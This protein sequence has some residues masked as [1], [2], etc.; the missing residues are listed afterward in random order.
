MDSGLVALHLNSMV[1]DECFLFRTQL[2]LRGAFSPVSARSQD[3]KG[4]SQSKNMMN[5]I[6]PPYSW[7]KGTL[8]SLFTDSQVVN[9]SK[10]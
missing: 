5:E 1:L 9:L 8:I 7:K 3:V 6:S 4:N 10:I 2:A